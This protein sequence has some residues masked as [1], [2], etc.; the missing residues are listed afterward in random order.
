M[1][2]RV[3]VC[4]CL[5]VWEA[6]LF[7]FH[8]QKALLFLRGPCAHTR[9]C[10]KLYCFHASL[11]CTDAHVHKAL[12]FPRGLCIHTCMCRKLYCYH[13]VHGL[14]KGPGG[15]KKLP[16]SYRER[17]RYRPRQQGDASEAPQRLLGSRGSYWC[18]R[19]S[20]SKSYSSS[21]S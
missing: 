12:L 17:L 16:S 4:V 7:P 8:A 13:V 11:A 6:L 10:R 21:P 15:L 5:R 18:Q 1:K 2:S 9:M 3:N 20:L 19:Q 14:G